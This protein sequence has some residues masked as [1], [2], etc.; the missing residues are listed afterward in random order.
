MS[1][2]AQIDAVQIE[3]RSIEEKIAALSTRRDELQIY[4]KVAGSLQARS[5]SAKKVKPATPPVVTGTK[6]AKSKAGTKKT[7][8]SKTKLPAQPV[9]KAVSQKNKPT[10]PKVP[11]ST[12]GKKKSQTP[13][14]TQQLIDASVALLKETSPL[15]PVDLLPK[16]EAR[17]VKVSGVNKA[18]QLRQITKILSASKSLF[19]SDRK[20][21]WSLV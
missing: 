12:G 15:K 4:L 3:L 5:T 6:P 8:S 1:T 16:I 18:K 14:L 10:T 9:K 17:G 13:S 11:V 21:G 2:P 19:K 20:L 7:A